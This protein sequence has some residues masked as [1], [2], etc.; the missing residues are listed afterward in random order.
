M[1][2]EDKKEATKFTYGALKWTDFAR[3]G[4]TALLVIDPQN[5]VL[6]PEGNLNY[7]KVWE[8]AEKNGVV[9][10]IK[11]LVLASRRA[12]VSIFWFR[13]LRLAGGKDIF[14]GTYDGARI[15]I[16]RQSNPEFELEGT[17]QIELIDE[18]KEIMT[19]NDIVM[20]KP[21]SSCFEGTNLQR[22]LTVL[23]TKALLICGVMTDFCVEGT[24][25]SA[26]DKGYMPVLVGDATA[27]CCDEDQRSALERHS[28]TTG[29]LT[30]TD[31][32]VEFLQSW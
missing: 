21:R 6:K 20:D 25:R 17:W 24:T 26:A 9:D 30:T 3:E 4:E 10:K 22:Y 15:A 29:P 11:S 32:V 2:P 28:R 23:G 8:Q 16:N 27:A 18:M 5:D 7:L 12:G 31:E 13:Q 14:P 19:D 1:S